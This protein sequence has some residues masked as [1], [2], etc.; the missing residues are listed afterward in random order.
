MSFK[1]KYL[2]R[3]L[4]YRWRE[5][6]AE[7]RF[8]CQHLNRGQVAVDLGSYKGAYTFWMRRQVG[9]SGCVYAFEPQSAQ[10]EYLRAAFSAMRYDNVELVPMAASDLCSERPLFIPA[11]LGK[12]HGASLEPL[13]PGH[14]MTAAYSVETIT[15][16]SFFE[17]QP[18]GPNFL[19][20]DVEGHELAVL[21]GARK[22][23]ENSRPIILLECEARHRADGDVWTV[24]NLLQS[25]GYEGSFFLRRRQIPLAEFDPVVHQ[26]LDE[27]HPVFLPDNYVNNFAFVPR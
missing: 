15:L 18:R 23:L 8:L 5:D 16:D 26:Q 12:S 27:S 6:R 25:L 22:V 19:K 4:R 21:H 10:I 14:A 17:N 13:M 2:Y 20:I 7:L 9:H 11:G 3:A 1:F 24:L